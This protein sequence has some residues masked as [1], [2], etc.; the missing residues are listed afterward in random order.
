MAKI[1]KGRKALGVGHLGYH[2]VFHTSSICKHFENCN[3]ARI[4]GR[5]CADYENCRTY[6]YFE[7]FNLEKLTSNLE[8]MFIG[9]K[10]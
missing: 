10:K 8:K 7:K 6:K 3:V 9:S 5:D 4:S 1:Y 2:K